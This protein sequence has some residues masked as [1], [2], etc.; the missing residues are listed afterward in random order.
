MKPETVIK[1]VER[2]DDLPT[3]PAIALEVNQ[4]LADEEADTKAIC[5]LIRQDQAMVPRIL[6]L[7]NSSF[8]GLRSK[9]INIERAAVLLG[10]RTLQNAIMSIA[11]DPEPSTFKLSDF[12]KHAIEVA[13][14]SKHLVMQ[15]RAVEPEEAFT[16]GLLHDIGKVVLV[17]YFPELFEAVLA[18]MATDA[19]SF[20][21]AE[22]AALGVTHSEIGAI[23][24]AKWLLPEQ[25][26]DV[27]IHHHKIDNTLSPAD[28]TLVVHTADW[29]A[30]RFNPSGWNPVDNGNLYS[31]ARVQYSGEIATVDD[32]YPEISEQIREGCTFFKEE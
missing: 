27:I 32:W 15:T 6:K 11:I 23:L 21:E 8:F 4:M 28:I 26:I 3:I 19:L 12:W 2:I 9:V 17:Q 7:V 14:I 31:M 1:L 22:T 13:T 24:G 10:S 30:R 18:S 29:I 20:Y 25:L 16:A 5:K